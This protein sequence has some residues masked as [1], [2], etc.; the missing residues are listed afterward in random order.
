MLV[1][2]KSFFVDLITEFRVDDLKKLLSFAGKS[3][4]CYLKAEYFSECLVLPFNEQV[5]TKI[6]EIHR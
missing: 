1:E 2:D 4:L 3:K 6:L 5:K